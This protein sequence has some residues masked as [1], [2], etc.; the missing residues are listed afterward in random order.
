MYKSIIRLVI[1]LISFLAFE[2]ISRFFFSSK[3]IVLLY[4]NPK[5]EIF[6]KHIEYISKYY[7]FLP[8]IELVNAIS[9]QNWNTI[10]KNSVVVTFDDG[11]IGNYELL[12][13]FRRKKIKPTIYL[14]T[15]IAATKRKFWFQIPTKAEETEK[16]KTI[17]NYERLNYLKTKF[18]FEQEKN[19]EDGPV[20]LTAL[21]IKEM[22]EFVD[23]QSHSKF[24]PILTKLENSELDIEIG[25][26]KLDLQKNEIFSEHFA[27]P[28]G[29]YS[30]RE[31]NYLKNSGFLSSR[32]TDIGF[33]DLKTNL[34]KL[35]CFGVSDNA[36][37]DKLKLQMSGVYGYMLNLIQNK[38]IYGLKNKN[39]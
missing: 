12:E 24:H 23:F 17:K 38:N 22:C 19:F 16:L 10:P 33:C 1:K 34:Y 14:C 29:D 25:S 11:H 30:E 5:K 36:D 7:N 9:K 27:F 31:I 18:Q 28:N 15:G 3:V 21:Q 13:I 20:S 32:T 26:N 2:K 8:L 4:H 39:E 6:E 37:I 35:K